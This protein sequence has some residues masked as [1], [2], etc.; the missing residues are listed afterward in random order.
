[1]PVENFEGNTFVAFLDISGFKIL[2]SDEQRALKALD[3]F[4]ETGFSVL[5]NQND[6]GNIRVDGF[7]ISDSGILFVRNGNE[8]SLQQLEVLLTSIQRINREML[9]DD[10]MLTTSV[11]YGRFT[12]HGRF[13]FKGIEK[14]PIYGD[15][16]VSAFLDNENGTPRI[17][18]GQCRIVKKGLPDHFDDLPLDMASAQFRKLK[19]N[20]NY[21]YF[22]W[23]VD[24]PEEIQQF[25]SKYNDAYNL[26]YAGM[27]QALKMRLA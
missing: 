20:R 22:F 24:E 27:L 3:R 10:F 19:A 26:K 2:M 5:Q 12:Y 7:F 18:P 16:Y 13:E 21:F 11:A 9:H 25:E 1:M 14:N 4:Y 23:M 6:Q 8:G 17:Q 15:A